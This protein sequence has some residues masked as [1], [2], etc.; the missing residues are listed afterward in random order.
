MI[1]RRVDTETSG[2]CEAVLGHGVRLFWRELGNPSGVPMLWI[3]GGSVED[4]SM[5][6]RDLAPFFDQLRVI[7]PDIRGHGR[8]ARFDDPAEYTWAAKCVDVVELLDHLGIQ[9]AVWGGNSMGAALSLWAAIHQPDRVRAVVDISGPPEPVSRHDATW[10]AEQRPL[11]AAGQ[12]AAYYEANVLHRSGPAALASLKAR[13]ERYAEIVELLHGHTVASFLALLDETY[14]RP[15]WL[16]QCS[17]I[18]C[19]TL[20][21][22][23]SLDAFPDEAQSRR[24]ADVIAGARLYMV[25]GG[26][27]FPNR[28]HRAEVQGVVRAF[29]T[30]IGVLA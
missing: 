30:D 21:I 28:T 4:S 14:A 13:P 3:H 27:H 25:E 8:S 11:V 1:G 23:G 5:M 15:G 7:L 10:W 22:G 12:F 9:R 20:V 17:R 29:L 26:P 19:P 24:V 2:E 6:V 16:D 18:E